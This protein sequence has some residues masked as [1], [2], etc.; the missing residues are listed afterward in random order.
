MPYRNA[1]RSRGSKK[2]FRRHFTYR[3]W[4]RGMRMARDVA[5]LK[6]VVN[7][8]RKYNDI[9]FANTVT[10]TENF[11]LLNGLATGDT[12]QTRE[13]Q[14]IKCT[15]S[16]LRLYATMNASATTTQLRIILLIDTQPNAQVPTSAELLTSNTNILSPLLIAY[17]GRFKV[18]LDKIFRMDTNKLN[19]EF[20]YYKKLRFHTKYNT[21]VDGGIDDITKNSYYLMMVSDQPT[22]APTVN[23]WHRLRFI[24]N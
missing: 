11:Q 18:C 21:N 2:G 3:N 12:G 20:K 10:E 17:G 15:A 16:F 14:S 1:R 7:V 19:V 22:N 5:W 8:E 6:S 13:G 9:T 23:W 24:D 4:G